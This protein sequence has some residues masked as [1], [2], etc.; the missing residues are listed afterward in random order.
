MTA[1]G[2]PTQVHGYT[3]PDGTV[4]VSSDR[5]A[6]RAA[7]IPDGAVPWSTEVPWSVTHPEPHMPVP[8]EPGSIIRAWFSHPGSSEITGPVFM[9]L[10]APYAHHRPHE[11]YRWHVMPPE[12]KAGTWGIDSDRIMWWESWHLEPGE[13]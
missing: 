3:M 5:H 8:T 4:V 6:K 9:W 13:Q 10:P 1:F 2:E 7:D 12:G 11:P